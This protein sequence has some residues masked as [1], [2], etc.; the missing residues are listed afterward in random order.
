MDLARRHDGRRWP[1]VLYVAA[2]AAYLGGLLLWLTLGM[3]PVLAARL[4][5]VHGALQDVAASGDWASGAARE[6]LHAAGM[7]QPL[8]WVAAQYLF[9]LMNLALGV[10]LTWLRPKDLVPRLLALAFIGT[11]G[12]FNEPSH[13]VFHLLGHAP[14]VTAVHFCFHVLSG[15]AYLWAVVLFPDGRLPW[16]PAGGSRRV[17]AVL[18]GAGTVLIVWVCYR[19]SFIAHP[20]FFV[21]FFGVLV[22]VVGMV[23]Q[24]ARLRRQ[25]PG[26]PSWAQSRLLRIALTPALLLAVAWL[27]GQAVHAVAGVSGASAVAARTTAVTGLA[28][29]WFPAVFALVPVMLVVAIL[30]YRL[31]DIDVI[32]SRALLLAMLGAFVAVGYGAALLLTG[33]ALPGRTWPAVLAMTAVGL[34]IEPVRRRCRAWS[35]TAVFG[36]RLSPREALA[37]LAAHLSR[38]ADGDDLAELTRVV[39]AGTRAAGAELWLVAAD[40]LALAAAAPGRPV[41]D[42]PPIPLPDPVFGAC[43]AALPDRR[44][45]PVHHDGRLVAVLA[46]T[47]RPGTSL[48]RDEATLVRELADHAGLLVANAQLGRDLAARLEQITAQADE[49]AGSRRR[50]VAAQDGARRR[51]ERDLHDGAQQE[52]VAIL[53]RVRALLDRRGS[54]EPT[55]LEEVRASVARTRAAVAELCRGRRPEALTRDGLDGA[56]QAA[57]RAAARGGPSVEVTC[58]LRRELSPEVETAIYFCCVE[59]LQ[60]T[61]KHARARRASISV[62][63]GAADVRCAISDDGVGYDPSTAARGSGLT[64]L[65]ERVADLGGTVTVESAA[66]HGSCTRVVVPLPAPDPPATAAL[67]PVG[68]SAEPVPS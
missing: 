61:I 7:P 30:R 22:S 49:L 53:I 20:P 35:N 65:A 23:A 50:L 27:A 46:L 3:L 1:T 6:A 44:C 15:T 4:P 13:E 54:V 66:T 56:L 37:A 34:A 63:A 55:G 47:L 2:F 28:Q 8:G 45:V 48:P 16:R 29:S 40:H 57:A 11:A 67:A 17:V 36:Q 64:N 33:W 14:L 68:P 5:A 12:T 21:V 62:E 52:L 38:S 58:R 25:E 31:W 24:S 9:S 60:N 43:A 32:V 59:A 39:V 26:T 10:L 41:G 19:S 42:E 18:L 51:L